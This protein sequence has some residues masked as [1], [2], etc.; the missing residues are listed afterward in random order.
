MSESIQVCDKCF[1][2]F[3]DNP[4]REHRKMKLLQ[5]TDDGSVSC[6][7]CGRMWNSDRKRTNDG[8]EPF[9]LAPFLIEESR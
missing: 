4:G 1:S 7:H 3:S 8:G 6:P 2:V 9:S 5:M